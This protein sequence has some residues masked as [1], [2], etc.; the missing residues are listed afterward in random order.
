MRTIVAD[1][2]EVSRQSRIE[3]LQAEETS[4]R[5]R[6]LL[7]EARQKASKVKRHTSKH[8]SRLTKKLHSLQVREDALDDGETAQTMRQ[9]CSRLERCVRKNFNDSSQLNL[10]TPESLRHGGLE[11]M[12]DLGGFQTVHE[13]RAWIHALMARFIYNDLFSPLFLG[14]HSKGMETISDEVQKLC[15]VPPMKWP[16]SRRLIDIGPK[17]VSEHWRLATSIA[18]E[19]AIGNELHTV[20]ERSIED[21]ERYFSVYSTTEAAAR[22]S[23]FFELMQ[24]CME[25]KRRLERQE[26]RYHF[27]S[28][29]PFAVYDPATMHSITGNGGAGSVILFSLWP[30]LWRGTGDNELQLIAPEQVWVRSTGTDSVLR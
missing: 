5:Q 16:V 4:R 22:A 25:F 26:F 30:A 17:H 9:M 14:I 7:H 1:Q 11:L 18:V 27:S 6:A 3:K 19:S 29:S 2:Y 13:R 8:L 20:F 23:Q 24:K 12:D 21:F 15:T 28:S 10:M